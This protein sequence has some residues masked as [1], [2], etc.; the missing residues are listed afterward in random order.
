VAVTI[1]DVAKH[2]GVSP[3]T[4]AYVVND[5]PSISAPTRAKVQAS[6]LA[7]GYVPNV[8][9]RNFR[10]GR[11]G[12]V[13]LMLPELGIPYF[14]ELAGAIIE[15]VAK[16]DSMAVIEQTDGD[17]EKER[18]L[19]NHKARAGVFDGFIFSPLGLGARE[20]GG[21]AR[22]APVVLLGERVSA[23][24]F[25]HVAIDN[26]AAAREAVEHLLGLGRRRIAAIGDQPNQADG[27]AR[28]RTRGY[29]DALRAAGVSYRRDL[30]VPAATF[31]RG[32]GAEAMERLLK[33]KEP[34]DAVFCYNDPLAAGALRAM[35][36][37]GMRVPEDVAL[38]GFD[39]IEEARYL[40]PTLTTISPDKHTIAALA[41][42]QLFR[43]LDGDAS[44]PVSLQAPYRL[45]VRESTIGA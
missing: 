16:R 20:I 2:A 15:E 12:M 29:R 45:E 44:D 13:A 14:A 36:R 34:P 21:R 17:P 37:A 23:G 9:A 11:S 18:A 40:T 3:R 33:L 25:D 4:V 24:P 38:V 35:L 7:L 8:A 43:R 19:L 42:Q 6:V 5:S 31:H 30:V 39:D 22:G 27:T 28:L 1:Y 10:R 26:V 41:V 32:P